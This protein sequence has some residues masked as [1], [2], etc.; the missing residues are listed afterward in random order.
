M[1]S[2]LCFD[3]NDIYHK[4]DDCKLFKKMRNNFCKYAE[5]RLSGLYK[6]KTFLSCKAIPEF[7]SGHYEKILEHERV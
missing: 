5:T 7:L 3:M 2:I 4:L 6:H 1:K